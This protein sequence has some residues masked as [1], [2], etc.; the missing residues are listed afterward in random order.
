MLALF[1]VGCAIHFALRLT[2]TR[3]AA[4]PLPRERDLDAESA[5][6]IDAM[7]RPPR[8][9]GGE[10]PESGEELEEEEEIPPE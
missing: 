9:C 8:G 4:P 1:V 10:W 5:A 7:P 6:M 3:V 2:I